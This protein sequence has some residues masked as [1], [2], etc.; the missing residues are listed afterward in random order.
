MD[1]PEANPS[2]F[3]SPVRTHISRPSAYSPNLSPQPSP[4][5]PHC[6][7]RDRLRLWK[8][9]L[10]VT[11]RHS[12]DQGDDI[13]R[14]FD[15]MSNA[16]A[17]STQESYSAGILVYHVYC[18][19]K[20]IPEELRAPT[21]QHTITAF[22]TSLAGSYSGSTISN[23]VHGIRA[24]H[25]LHGLEWRLNPLEMDAVL[26]GADRLAP[27][28][29]KRKK[30][31]PYTPEFITSLRQHL[32]LDDSFDAAV[33]ACLTTCFYAAARVGEFL[34]PRLDAFAPSL[35]VTSDHSQPARRS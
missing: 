30:R 9:S 18:D 24:W 21:N 7:A 31:Q 5:R 13:E 27:P 33:F 15:V 1:Q 11:S 16:W 23:Y 20:D 8:P 25:I 22:I 4:L 17:R 6:L 2:P 3:V 10:A 19:A 32:R 14:V 34:V 35:H 12:T 28:S 26:K 29:S